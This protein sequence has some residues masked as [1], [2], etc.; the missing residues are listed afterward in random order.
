MV[1]I[2]VFYGSFNVGLLAL[3]ASISLMDL[4]R[5]FEPSQV[6]NFSLNAKDD[7]HD[8]LLPVLM[9]VINW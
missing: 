2:D 4:D 5:C 6:M 9:G 8:R 3:L 7:L 1:Y